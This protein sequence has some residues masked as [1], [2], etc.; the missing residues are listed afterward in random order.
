MTN[1]FGTT[2]DMIIQTVEEEG[3]AY[4]VAIDAK[5][6]YLTTPG[7]LNE[8]IADP[9]RYSSRATVTARLA[10]LGMDPAAL[11]NEHQHLIKIGGGDT[12]KKVNPLKASKRRMKS[13]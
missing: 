11:L 6:L 3:V 13:A 5:G 2:Q 4:L 1:R 8:R 9:N 7:R 10:A 12:G